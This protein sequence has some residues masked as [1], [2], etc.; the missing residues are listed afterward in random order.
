[1]SVPAT[2]AFPPAPRRTMTRTA[3]SL[4]SAPQN[5]TRASYIGQVMALRASG[6]LNVTV[7]MGPS[8]S[9]TTCGVGKTSTSWAA[10]R[11]GG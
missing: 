9:R 7:A 1:M 10:A 5:S 2:K 6:R 4:S 11:R 3:A 8:R